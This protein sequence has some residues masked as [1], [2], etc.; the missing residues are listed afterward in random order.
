MT[1]NE[2]AVYDSVILFGIAAA[3]YEVFLSTIDNVTDADL[4]DRKKRLRQAE[5]I[6]TLL[7]LIFGWGLSRSRGNMWGLASAVGVSGFFLIVFESVAARP[8]AWM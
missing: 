3:S 4:K 8:D 6:V 1:I 7:V 2:Q 5:T